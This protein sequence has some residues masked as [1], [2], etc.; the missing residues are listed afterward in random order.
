M[1]W[2]TYFIGIYSRSRISLL[3]YGLRQCIYY[4]YYG[5]PSVYKRKRENEKESLVL[6]VMAITNIARA[7]SFYPYIN[8]FY[9]SIRILGDKKAHTFKRPHEQKLS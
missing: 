5:V 8:V 9:C 7:I 2:V 4:M 6:F 3:L 1:Q